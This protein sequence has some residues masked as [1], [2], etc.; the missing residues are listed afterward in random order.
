MILGLLILLM[1]L[2]TG[3]NEAT[4][5]CDTSNTYEGGD[6][7]TTTVCTSSNNEKT[8][9]V[10]ADVSY[11]LLTDEFFIYAEDICSNEGNRVNG[12]EIIEVNLTINDVIFC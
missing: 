12:F 3:C 11:D 2:L 1:V 8:M 10:T 4:W 5:T 7:L 9:V 6:S